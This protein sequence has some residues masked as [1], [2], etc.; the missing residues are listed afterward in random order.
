MKGT[1]MI[2]KELIE[3]LRKID[4]NLNI[5]ILNSDCGEFLNLDIVGID[6]TA[7]TKVIIYASDCPTEDVPVGDDYENQYGD[8]DSSYGCDQLG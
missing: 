8:G 7:G 4:E 2:V 5:I 1:K 6:K 3:Q